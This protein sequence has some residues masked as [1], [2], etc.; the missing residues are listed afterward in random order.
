MF[1]NSVKE[2]LLVWK[3]K[4]LDKRWRKVWSMAS[5]C[6]FCCVWDERNRRILDGEYLHIHGQKL[7]EIPIKSLLE[8]SKGMLGREYSPMVDF[9]DRL[10]C[11]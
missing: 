3:V 4:G 1:P 8:W 2:L 10:N 6:F 5:L 7:K 11:G 9:I